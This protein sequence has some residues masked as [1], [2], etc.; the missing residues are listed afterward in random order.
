VHRFEPLV[1]EEELRRTHDEYEARRKSATLNT[2]APQPSGG[3]GGTRTGIKC[4]HAHVANHLAGF[5]DP[6]GAL[7]VEEIALPPLIIENVR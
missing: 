5:N 6:V 4:L 2:T 7:V 1:D 3:V